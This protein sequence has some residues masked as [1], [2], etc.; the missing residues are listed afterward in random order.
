MWWNSKDRAATE[1]CAERDHQS[2]GAGDPE[3]MSYEE[4]VRDGHWM[5]DDVIC[6][7]EDFSEQHHEIYGTAFSPQGEKSW[8]TWWMFH[9]FDRIVNQHGMAQ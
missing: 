1:A 2:P 5:I 8:G 9:A 7:C 4:Y 3:R 6:H